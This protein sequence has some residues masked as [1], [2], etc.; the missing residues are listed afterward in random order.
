MAGAVLLR[1]TAP[2]SRPG[3]RV[4]FCDGEGA[5]QFR[6]PHL[7]WYVALMAAGLPELSLGIGDDRLTNAPW[8]IGRRINDRTAVTG[9][10]FRG[11][12]DIV[13]EDEG[14]VARCT[15]PNQ[16][17]SATTT[18]S[19]TSPSHSDSSRTP[20]HASGPNGFPTSRERRGARC[21]CDRGGRHSAPRGGSHAWIQHSWLQHPGFLGS[22]LQHQVGPARSAHRRPTMRSAGPWHYSGVPM[23]ARVRRSVPTISSSP[24]ETSSP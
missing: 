17:P 19:A 2:L 8:L 12:V 15:S 24:D 5:E 9:C 1:E 22:W 10:P 18:S 13:N 16:R 4:V 11:L 7:G 6:P 23:I 14:H 3:S 21:P 20:K